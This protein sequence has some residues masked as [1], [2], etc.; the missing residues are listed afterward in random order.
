MS[1]ETEAL[2]REMWAMEKRLTE[3][4]DIRDAVLTAHKA[5]IDRIPP[6]ELQRDQ[7]AKLTA[8]VSLTDTLRHTVAALAET[9][10]EHH[11]AIGKLQE[12]AMT[13]LAA[14]KHSPSDLLARQLAEARQEN[15]ELRRKLAQWERIAERDHG[16]PLSGAIG[17]KCNACGDRMSRYEDFPEYQHEGCGG[18]VELAKIV[19][20][21]DELAQERAKLRNY[22]AQCADEKIEAAQRQTVTAIADWLERRA[23][24]ILTPNRHCIESQHRAAGLTDAVDALRAGT[25]KET[26]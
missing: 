12:I 20:L 7:N 19:E 15:Q 14:A 11:A 24:E 6:A 22:A 1:L 25:W 16:K 17:Y 10:R 23:T 9:S 3:R 4:L 18:L 8:L 21:R 13:P 2:R 5:A 26:P